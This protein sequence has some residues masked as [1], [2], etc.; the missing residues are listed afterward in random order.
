[1]TQTE[2]SSSYLPNVAYSEADLEANRQG[3]L[4]QDQFEIV[5]AVYQVRRQMARQTY[6]LFALWI[7]LLLIVGIV[8]EYNQSGKSLGEFLPGALPIIAL[9]GGLLALLMLIVWL[10]TALN[11]RD[12][13]DKRISVAEGEAYVTEKEAHTRGAGSYMRYELRL[14]GRLFR[15]ANHESIAH[16]EGGKRYRVYYIKY[17]PFP[18][19]LSAEII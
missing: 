6:K 15:F 2:Y 13:R 3:W 10:F 5:E 19:M 16:F 17:Y 9:V 11:A 8:I 4:T 7:P 12:A 18:L 1:M 14:N